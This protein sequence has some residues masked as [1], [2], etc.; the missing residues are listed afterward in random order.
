M[1]A[2]SVAHISIE[3]IVANVGRGALHPFYGDG[4]FGDI[5]VVLHEFR[6]IRWRLPVKLFRY[7]RPELS[8][9]VQGLLVEFRVLVKTGYVGITANRRIR[10]EY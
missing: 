3:Q 10:T 7:A 5:E 1:I 9:I 8:W 4:S 2:Q 6:G